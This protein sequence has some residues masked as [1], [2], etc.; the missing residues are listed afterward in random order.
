M[1]KGPSPSSI[2]STFS[3]HTYDLITCLLN[4]EQKKNITSS[5]L[6]KLGYTKDDYIKQFP[7]AP[8]ISNYLKEIR[9]K[10][11]TTLNTSNKHFQKKRKKAVRN[12]LN[13]DRSIEYRKKAS[14]KAKKQHANGLDEKVRGYFKERYIGSAE[15]IRRS[16]RLLKSPL[17]KIP[18][19][20][21]KKKETYI[22]NSKLGLHNKETK[23][24]KKRYKN[25]DLIYQ[26]SYE[27][28]FLSFCEKVGILD[29]IKNSH[30]FTDENY[31]YNFYQPDYIFD[32][33]YIIE[34]KSW[35]IENLQEKKYPGILKIKEELIIKHGYKF[36]YI[37]DKDYSPLNNLLIG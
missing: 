17:N 12:F 19:V 24:K 21:E 31:P 20:L 35:Y 3:N 7:G 10:N 27:L 36:L 29:V 15:Q 11:M 34:I 22:N 30:C 33:K 28:D 26:S 8:L 4:G 6:K 32:N 1:Y 14:E 16:K 23:F 13:S 37:K 5:Y 25:T 9:S 2:N 18:G